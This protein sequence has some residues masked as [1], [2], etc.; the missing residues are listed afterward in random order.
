V[1]PFQRE[2]VCRRSTSPAPLQTYLPF[3]WSHS[4][5]SLA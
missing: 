5:I 3:G 2:E 1:R 4:N